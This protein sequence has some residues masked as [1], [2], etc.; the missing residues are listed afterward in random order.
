[1]ERKLAAVGAA[2]EH[3]HRSILGE[4][5]WPEIRL[6][7]MEEIYGVEIPSQDCGNKSRIVQGSGCY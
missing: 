5:L 7:G 1:M 2:V 3:G 4:I 6:L